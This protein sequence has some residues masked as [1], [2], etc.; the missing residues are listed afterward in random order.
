M[1]VG[2]SVGERSGWS[3]SRVWNL[4]TLMSSWILLCCSTLFTALVAT[5]ATLVFVRSDRGREG[6]LEELVSLLEGFE[7]RVA[8][9]DAT[10]R[11]S[12]M[13]MVAGE[14]DDEAYF[15]RALQDRVSLA[16]RRLEP[17]A[18]ALLALEGAGRPQA[19]ELSIN[20][21]DT[22]RESDLVCLLGSD[23]V[24]IVFDGVAAS[25]GLQAVERVWNALGDSGQDPA[26]V[27]AGV[28]C[29]PTHALDASDLFSRASHALSKVE[30]GAHVGV[31]LGG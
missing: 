12:A 21:R 14:V 16:R 8:Q 11:G 25:G 6:Q 1:L 3:R 2:H 31:A 28:A 13:G 9:R 7:D 30:L 22:V 29:Y 27:R 24:A 4:E 5:G 17:V 26:K 20:L 10:G 19:R 23:E 18:L 15:L